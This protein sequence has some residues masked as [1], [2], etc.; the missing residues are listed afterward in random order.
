MISIEIF[1]KMRR[2]S[3]QKEEIFKIFTSRVSQKLLKSENWNKHQKVRMFFL[4]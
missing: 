4:E 3:I 2:D 1:L